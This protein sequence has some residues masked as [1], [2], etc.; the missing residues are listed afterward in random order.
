[1]SS[2]KEESTFLQKL[3]GAIIVTIVFFSTPGMLVMGVVR[4][5]WL[6]GLDTGQ[7]WTFSILISIAGFALVSI[8]VRS[9]WAG[10]GTHLCL[11][12]GILLVGVIAHFGL[13]AKWPSLIVGQ[14]DQSVP[15]LDAG[16]DSDNVEGRQTDSSADMRLMWVAFAYKG[17]NM[18]LL[19]L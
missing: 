19:L 3:V 6:P 11:C 5:M 1:M 13:K 15:S 9:F 7:M 10:L 16:S 17:E 12:L 18:A 8:M 14:F 2:D 4:A